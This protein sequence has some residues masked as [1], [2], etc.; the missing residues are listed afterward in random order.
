MNKMGIKDLAAQGV[1][2]GVSAHGIG[3]AKAIES[4]PES[5]IFSGLAMCLN[6]LITAIITPYLLIFLI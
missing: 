6:G 1:A 5:G 3:T 4:S 2:M